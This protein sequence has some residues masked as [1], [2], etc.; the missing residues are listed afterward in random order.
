MSRLERPNLP[1]RTLL[2]SPEFVVRK[3]TLTKEGNDDET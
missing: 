3:S 2:L 1:A